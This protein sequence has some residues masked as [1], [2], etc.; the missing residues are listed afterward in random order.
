MAASVGIAA[1]VVVI[2]YS[3]S[4]RLRTDA[5]PAL[6]I[7]KVSVDSAGDSYFFAAIS[8]DGKYVAYSDPANLHVKLI[9]T[10]EEK[11]IPL[12]QISESP[13]PP[14][15]APGFPIAWFPDGTRLL[16]TT[17]PGPTIWSIA[18]VAGSAQKLFGGGW[19]T[20]VSPDGTYIAFVQGNREIWLMGPHGEQPRRFLRMPDAYEVGSVFWAP[21]SQ[22]IGYLKTPTTLKDVACTMETRDLA[23][24]QATVI[25]SDADLCQSGLQTFFWA[26]DGRIVFDM[27]ETNFDSADHNLWEI[28]VDPRNGKSS[29]NARRLTNW[30]GSYIKMISGSADG[31]RVAFQRTQFHNDIKIGEIGSDG[32]ILQDSLQPFETGDSTNWPTSWTP[33]SRGVLYY[34]AQNGDYDI[35]EKEPDSR[36]SQPIVT[37]HGEQLTPRL[38]PDGSS[39]I[40]MDVPN[41]KNFN[42]DT[43]VHLMRV[44]IAG[45]VSENVFT[46]H[47]YEGHRC[48]RGPGNLCVVGERSRDGEHFL[49]FAFDPLKSAA[50][51]DDDRSKRRELFSAKIRS[52][53]GVGWDLSPDGARLA[54]ATSDGQ[55]TRVQ[56]VSL[57]DQKTTEAVV[58]GLGSHSSLDWAGDGRSLFMS[59]RVPDGVSLLQVDLRGNSRVVEHQRSAYQTWA[60]PSPNGRRVAV[61]TARFSCD[62]WLVENF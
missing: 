15:P 22:R 61:F 6:R 19:G 29:G 51:N 31:K 55:N 58:R 12:P 5:A 13:N 23:G 43:P 14:N 27:S 25:L 33:D 18:L 28:L 1:L 34:S 7:Q 39:L 40:Y 37:G 59:Q 53:Q 42:S 4:R 9:E 16:V 52:E 38:S 60:I 44:P 11:V 57:S 17:S 3:S 21:D 2:L 24:Q 10:G 45:G 8:P 62:V 35:F 48:S 30:A 20:S 46:S 47:G 54:I 32:S 50:Q 26:P 56:F 36:A 49:F 41:F